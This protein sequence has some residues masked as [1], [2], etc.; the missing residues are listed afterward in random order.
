MKPFK[1]FRIG[2]VFTPEDGREIIVPDKY[3][4]TYQRDIFVSGVL[5]FRLGQPRNC[6]ARRNLIS[7]GS[8]LIFDDGWFAETNDV[9][10]ITNNER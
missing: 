4:T 2:F 5:N 8:K 9:I 1:F 6:W 10:Y 7:H 3:N